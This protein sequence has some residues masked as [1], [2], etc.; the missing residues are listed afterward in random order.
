MISVFGAN[1]DKIVIGKFL[2]ATSLG[3]YTIAR[4]LILLPIRKINPILTKVAFPV[5]SKI[6]NRGQLQSFYTKAVVYLVLV[7]IPLILGL[8]FVSSDFVVFIYGQ[9]WLPSAEII[10]ILS[11][12]ALLRTF[13]SLSGSILLSR[14][15]SD[16]EFYWHIVRILF[17]VI[18]FYFLL[19]IELS[20]SMAA[21]AMVISAATLAVFWH[22]III[23]VVQLNYR[24]LLKEVIQLV[25]FGLIMGL[26]IYMVDK[27]TFQ[28]V[29]YALICKVLAGGL[30]YTSLVVIFKKESLEFLQKS[31]F[32]SKKTAVQTRN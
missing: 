23:R 10:Q 22:I 20:I 28:S 15:R 14:G 9:K 6:E 8:A 29:F 21:W 4:Q 18:C 16:I 30:I 27:I 3:Y 24:Q 13:G 7:N 2:D 17:T 5:F 11:I 19:S 25:S 32:K 1:L 31:F 26:G 12:L